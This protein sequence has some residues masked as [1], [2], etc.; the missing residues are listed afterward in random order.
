MN[1]ANV[2]VDLAETLANIG[3]ALAF[4]MRYFERRDGV[5][6]SPDAQR[7]RLFAMAASRR[8]PA[9]DVVTPVG[10]ALSLVKMEEKRRTVRPSEVAQRFKITRQGVLARLNRD[11]PTLKGEKD[12]HD[13]WWVEIAEVERVYGRK[14]ADG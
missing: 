6:Y 1:L 3:E 11:P 13:E 14:W 12:D 2:P 7:M 4:G 9:P 8:H 10:P 5:T